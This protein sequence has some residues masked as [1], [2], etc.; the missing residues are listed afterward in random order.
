VFQFFG[1]SP[2]RPLGI[3]TSP[4]EAAAK[5]RAISIFYIEPAQQFRVVVTKLDK[6]KVKFVSAS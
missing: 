5:T 1:K 3:I 2:A 6:I 4:D